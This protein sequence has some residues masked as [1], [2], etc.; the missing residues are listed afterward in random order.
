MLAECKVS[1][2]AAFRSGTK[3]PIISFCRAKHERAERQY[4]KGVAKA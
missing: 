1:T 3:T 4:A 2:W